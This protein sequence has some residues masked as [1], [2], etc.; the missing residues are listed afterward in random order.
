MSPL[1]ARHKGRELEEAHQKPLR[2]LL[3][4]AVD[5]HGSVSD[6]AKALGV[7][8]GTLSTWLAI[9]QLRLKTIVVSRES[10]HCKPSA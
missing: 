2:D 1:K 5:T 3:I 4:E 6:A 10:D 7:S 8:Q 9:H